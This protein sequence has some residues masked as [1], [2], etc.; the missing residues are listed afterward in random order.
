M[1]QQRNLLQETSNLGIVAAQ[2]IR[3]VLGLP[4]LRLGSDVAM[5]E[6][7]YGRNNQA[8]ERVLTQV[9]TLWVAIKNIGTSAVIIGLDLII[10]EDVP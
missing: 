5:S 10:P 9:A 3:L 1:S 2:A 6:A 4:F 8:P 7:F